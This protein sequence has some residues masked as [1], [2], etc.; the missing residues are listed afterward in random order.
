M[1]TATFNDGW[2]FRPKASVFSELGG[3]G[4]AEWE[5]IAIPHDAMLTE[6]RRN[7]LPNGTTTGHFPG[8][9]YQ[10][11]RSLAIDAESEGDLIWLHFE[12]VYRNAAVYVNGTLA[13]QRASGYSE[14][15]VRIDPYLRFGKDNEIVVEC[16]AG[17]D[18][19]WY[20]GAGIYRSVQLIRKAPLHISRVHAT[21]IDVD[22]DQAVVEVVSVARNDSTV[23]T[24]SR[25]KTSVRMAGHED[26]VT[27]HDAP[28]TVLPGEEVT[29]RQRLY[30]AEP[31]LWSADTPALYTAS[32][33]LHREDSDVTVDEEDITFG[34]RTLQVDPRHGLRVNGQSVKLR[35]ACV[36]HDNG[37]L[38]AATWPEA[39]ERRVR[40]LKEAGFNAIRSAHNPM[41]RAML[42][43]CDRL[44]MYVMDE[45][46]DMWTVSKTDEDYSYD[47]PTW[48]ERDIESMVAKDVNHPS[49][50]IY[51]IGNE[52]PENGTPFGGVQ[53][54][55]LAEKIRTL[56]PTRPI[57]NGINGFV[58]IVDEVLDAMRARGATEEAGGVNTMMAQLGDM[59]NH[60]AVSESVTTRTE[61]SQGALDIAGMNYAESRY[62][63]DAQLFPERIIVG[64]ESFP[65]RIAEIWRLVL[66]NPHVIGDFTW[67]G[68]DYLGEAGIGGIDYIDETLDTQPSLAHGYPWLLA[69]CG[70]IDITGHRRPASYYR[71]IVFG[72]RAD[73]YIA[74]QRPEHH[75]KTVALATPWA[76][77]D[78]ISS[79][80]WPGFED[81]PI[82]VE[83]Y[84]AADE[85][86]LILDGTEIG[87]EP[88]GVQKPFR[89]DFETVYR[90]GALEAVAY[91]QGVAVG[92]HLLRTAHPAATVSIAVE[93]TPVRQAGS[94]R[95]AFVTLTITDE[96]GS[97][98]STND[99]AIRIEVTASASVLGFGSANPQNEE[100]YRALQHRTFDGRALAVI[101]I[102]PGT[103]PSI[104]AY[105][106]GLEPVTVSLVPEDLTASS[107]QIPLE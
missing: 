12:G 92:R 77:T 48:W 87:R 41:S 54:R 95:M 90:P 44:G 72:L 49:V 103:S 101:S 22:A 57:T 23:T 42:E 5:S 52:I 102:A 65:T 31:Q 7:D 6:T 80:T 89:A 96:N 106:D 107:N 76:W 83:V 1:T 59:M 14:F 82:H 4:V 38:G 62:E 15:T 78:T 63:L 81:E 75:G 9:A 97:P 66:A 55:K 46:F 35:G 105:T 61:E 29:V 51:S 100:G 34:I 36:H 67:T 99:R 91:A 68:W 25:L 40:I 43:A 45:A 53:S 16:R 73:P 69:Y 47:F 27:S 26:V 71:E 79:W 64:T 37:V 2:S 94:P 19:R 10:Y 58:A 18:T 70:D 17:K 88:I 28:V 3:V 86:A 21:T 32:T 8:G 93:N 11:R 104:T 24:R 50:I 74:V 33:S 13:G 20:S 30:L 39:E 60:I 85:V 84:A 98:V 56:D